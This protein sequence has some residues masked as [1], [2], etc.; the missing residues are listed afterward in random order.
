MPGADLHFSLWGALL[1]G[2]VVGYLGGMLGVGGG[3]IANPLLNGVLGI[4][5]PVV[6]GTSLCQ[7]SGASL[8]GLLRHRRHGQFDLRIAVMISGGVFCGEEAGVAV[9]EWLKTLGAVRLAGGSY[10]LS[11][12][13]L[14]LAFLA[15]LVII[16]GFVLAES[17]RS[18]LAPRA[19]GAARRGWL[20]R[21][22]LPPHVTPAGGSPV[23]APLVALTGVPIGL[24]QGLLGIGGGVLM[25]PVL[26]YLIGISTHAAIGT[27][28][29]IV[30]AGSL[31]GTFRH[32][33]NGNVSL[34]LAAALL[35]A[36]TFGSQLGAL[37]STRLK[38]HHLRQYFALV[39]AAAAVILAWKLL[40]M[41]GVQITWA[42]IARNLTER[43]Q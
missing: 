30:L 36:S 6:S 8:S 4:P 13:V 25:L 29:M 5:M 24:A 27:S 2:L 28:L 12:L 42:D 21:L 35:A 23:S 20:S 43:Y 16:G 10:P 15:M 7:I 31:W 37:T 19:P 11:E 40:E 22:R 17:R 14:R 18:A 41:L 38:A 1:I 3:F 9:V 26:I 34:E 39:V 32:A 33:L